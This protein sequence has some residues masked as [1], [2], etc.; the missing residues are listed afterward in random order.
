[1]NPSPNTRMS[2]D[3]IARYYQALEYLSFGTFLEK[4]RFAFVDQVTSCRRAILC[5]D[6]DGRFLARLLGA[7]SSVH[8]DFVDL[9]EAMV[10]LARKRV[11]RMG[12]TFLQRVTFAVADVREFRPAGADYDLIATHFFLD[13][14]TECELH[15]VISC[16]A[17]WATPDARWIVSEFHETTT[18]FGRL[19][20]RA[21]IRGLYAA[22]RVT[23]GLR[24]TRLPNY[25]AALA[26]FGYAPSHE[27]CML[28]GLLQSSLWQSSAASHIS[29]KAHGFDRAAD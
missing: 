28:R 25:Q 24:V 23:T 12:E 16:L 6:G 13:C 29:A 21:M 27:K 8:V 10:H 14:F 2:C 11:A 19:C 4:S 18:P 1:V 22:F 20:S 9:S 26:K 7:N 15:D 3:S 5:G 17:A